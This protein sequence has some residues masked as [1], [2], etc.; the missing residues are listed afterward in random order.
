MRAG[1]VPGR[2]TIPD[3]LSRKLMP[4]LIPVGIGIA[5]VEALG[6]LDEKLPIGCVQVQHFKLRGPGEL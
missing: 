4:R 1:D 2:D 5:E 3:C 6:G